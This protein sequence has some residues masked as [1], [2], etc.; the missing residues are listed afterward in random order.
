M[1]VSEYIK[2][3]LGPTSFYFFVTIYIYKNTLKC[4]TIKENYNDAY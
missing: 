3:K 2:R 1:T 4:E